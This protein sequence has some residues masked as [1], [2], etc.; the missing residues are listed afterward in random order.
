MES[1]GQNPD[2]QPKEGIQP[3]LLP[4]VTTA[5]DGT[6]IENTGQVLRISKPGEGDIIIPFKP[7]E[8]E[9]KKEWWEH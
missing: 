4:G 1:K 7:P 3:P 5:R 6:I 9:P 2:G 8:K